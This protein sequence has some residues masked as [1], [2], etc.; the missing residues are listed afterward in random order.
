MTQE[1]GRHHHRDSLLLHIYIYIHMYLLVASLAS[2]T[3]F[4]IVVD[5]DFTVTVAVIAAIKVIAAAT[6]VGKW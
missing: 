3:V 5:V 1:K 2:P 6:N 4:N